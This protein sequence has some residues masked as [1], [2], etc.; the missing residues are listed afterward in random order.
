LAFLLGTLGCGDLPLFRKPPPVPVEVL[1]ARID[2]SLRR[3][4]A[5][6]VLLPGQ[7]PVSLAAVAGSHPLDASPGFARLKDSYSW[8]AASLSPAVGATGEFVAP[9]KAATV[10]RVPAAG[11]FFKVS[12]LVER[13]YAVPRGT[14]L[15]GAAREI[16]DGAFVVSGTAELLLE[17]P[18]PGSRLVNGT[19]DGI[20][21]GEYPDPLGQDAKPIVRK[22]PDVYR[23]PDWFYRVDDTN[24]PL[25]VSPHFTLGDFDLTHDY[26]Q[27]DYPA[28]YEYIALHPRL[29]DKL[30]IL[31]DRIRAAVGPEAN[32]VLLAGFRSPLHNEK[33]KRMELDT[34]QTSRFSMHLYG[35][36][37]DFFVDADGDGRMDDVDR[38]GT[39]GINDA[40][41]I[42]GIV[43]GIDAEHLPGTDSVLGGCGVYPRHDITAR[44]IQTPYVHVDVRG[45]LNDLAKPARWEMP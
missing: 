30:E 33:V 22:H 40:R 12:C 42:R 25:R 1:D 34:T 26:W 9:R 36:A 14:R 13:L 2:C 37:A 27:P 6:F 23:V 11:G 15:S 44:E 10:W 31:V 17:V 18:T 3:P 28:D 39:I 19:L 43:D 29:I 32:L 16:A 5:E 45:Y 4:G 20:L 35:R 7:E 38:D 41:Y 21:L 24:R 8:W